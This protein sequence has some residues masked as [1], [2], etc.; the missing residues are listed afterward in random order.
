VQVALE[1]RSQRHRDAQRQ[2]RDQRTA[3]FRVRSRLRCQHAAD[4][5]LAELRRIARRAAG[6][7]VGD[8]AGHG[9]ADAGYRV[10]DH[11]DHGRAQQQR[12]MPEHGTDAVEHAAGE[13]LQPALARERLAPA[14][15]QVDDLRQREQP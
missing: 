6:V 12:E 2:R 11:A 15:H 3:V 4:V 14:D 1:H 8:E 13:V 9:A 5:A 7:S 10:H